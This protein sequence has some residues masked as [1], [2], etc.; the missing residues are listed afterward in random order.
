MLNLE[1]QFSGNVGKKTD[2]RHLVLSEEQAAIR[3]A[4]ILV[5]AV[6]MGFTLVLKP[7]ADHLLE[8]LLPFLTF[9]PDILL[10]WGSFLLS[11][12]VL[13][14]IMR[15]LHREL[16]IDKG[17]VT[18]NHAL[19]SRHLG[20]REIHD[21]GISYLCFGMVLLY[22]SREHLD[23][24]GTGRKALGSSCCCILLLPTDLKNVSKLMAVCRRYSRVRPFLC[25]DEGKLEGIIRNR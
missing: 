10:K 18:M 21:F 17:G 7:L 23:S 13:G 3:T 4:P 24:T 22:F 16:F 25:S 19:H 11:V 5:L 8:R 9:L 1:P 2:M 20:W 14:L 6:L 15:L 12:C